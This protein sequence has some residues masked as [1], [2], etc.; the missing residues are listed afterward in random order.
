MD[1][2]CENLSGIRADNK[3]DFKRHKEYLLKRAIGMIH[4]L[5]LARFITYAFFFFLNLRFNVSFAICNIITDPQAC[6]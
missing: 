4:L 6:V 2:K 1:C 5:I 3:L